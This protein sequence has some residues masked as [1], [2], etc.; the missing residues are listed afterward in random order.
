MT[1]LS[2][3]IS[4]VTMAAIACFAVAAGIV[5]LLFVRRRSLFARAVVYCADIAILVVVVMFMIVLPFAV[6]S[7]YIPSGSMR[8]TL[9]DDDH[10]LVN[11]FLYRIHRP[12]S[13][14]VVVFTAPPEALAAG[15][16][17]AD[18]SGAP[19]DYIKR[20]IG[21]PGDTIEVHAGVIRVGPAGAQQTKSHDDVRQALQIQDRDQDHVKFFPDHVAVFQARSGTWSSVSKDEMAAKL[22]FPQ[23]PIEISP[24]YVL[25]NGVRLKEPYIA[26]D[27]DYDMKYTHGGS[28]TRDGRGIIQFDSSE[29][30]GGFRGF[31]DARSEPLPK[32]RLLVF[33][34]N[35]NLSNDSSHWGSLDEK[36]LIGK[37]FLIFYPVS[38][39]GGLH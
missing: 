14:D 36:L 9:V 31:K 23:Q 24:G 16:E 13:G 17:E 18:G 26:E 8:P 33:G 34:D 5:R 30:G 37:A 7:F 15:N 27:P 3:S 32:D 10:I 28:L 19:I 6:K 25:R 35:R 2:Q 11:K 22:G 12:V 20:I 29:Y 38:R 21:M 1:D 39:I 4:N